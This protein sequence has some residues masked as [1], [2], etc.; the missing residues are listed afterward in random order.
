[1]YAYGTY[2]GICCYMRNV[3]FG[4]SAWE[5]ALVLVLLFGDGGGFQQNIAI[6]NGVIFII[7]I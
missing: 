2:L 3:F 6:I 4:G 1:M 7:L 5:F